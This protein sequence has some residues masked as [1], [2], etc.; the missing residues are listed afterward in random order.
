MFN[1][2]TDLTLKAR[3]ETRPTSIP[4]FVSPPSSPAAVAH[5]H[6]GLQRGERAGSRQ[7]EL[8]KDGPGPRRKGEE[9]ARAPFTPLPHRRF[10]RDSNGRDDQQNVLGSKARA[11]FVCRRRQEGRPS[12]SEADRDADVVLFVFP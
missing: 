12:P 8:L 3:F 4:L 10:V 1:L 5:V 11:C 2:E 6:G 7:S 9:S